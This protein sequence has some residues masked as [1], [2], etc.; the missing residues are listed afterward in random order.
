MKLVETLQKTTFSGRR[1]TRKQLEGIQETVHQFRNLSRKELAKTLCEHLSWT[2]PNGAYKIHSC[3]ALLDKLAKQEIV[4]LPA[5][6]QTKAPVRQEVRI[7]NP[8]EDRPINDTFSAISPIE[9]Q[10]VTTKED[11]NR[12]KA[13]VQQYHYLGYEHAFGAHLC[14]GRSL[15]ACSFRHQRGTLTEIQISR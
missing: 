12:W 11:R 1:F 3:Y 6:R 2:S 10:L 8:E 7:E 13:Y 4:V 5:K 14:L 15:D 9:L